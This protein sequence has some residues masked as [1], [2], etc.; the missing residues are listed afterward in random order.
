MW[1]LQPDVITLG[2][3]VG[4]GLP[5]G[6]YGFTDEL[7]GQLDAARNIAT[8]S[9]LVREPAVGG[10]REGRADQD[11]CPRRLRARD[12]PRHRARRRDRAGN[13]LGRSAVDS[14][15]ARPRSGQWYGPMPRT[16]AQ[17]H[18]LTDDQLTRLIRI[19]PANR[20]VWK[21]LPGAGQQS[22]SPQHAPTWPATSRTIPSCLLNC[23]N[24]A[25]RP[26]AWTHRSSS[27]ARL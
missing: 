26:R 14:D 9:H 22:L 23:T 20:G 1:Q 13:H 11:P 3:A 15:P 8:G 16:G 7:G 24:P 2:K 21:A 27:S 5:M 18:A 12:R 25:A 6:A 19:W 17:A 4:G 10:G